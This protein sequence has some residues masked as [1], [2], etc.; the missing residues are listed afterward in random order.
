VKAMPDSYWHEWRG[1]AADPG[2]TAELPAGADVVVVGG[3][4][5]GTATAYWLARRGMKPVLLER[6]NL[7]AG[8][9]GRNGGL[10]VTG[11]PGAYPVAIARVGRETARAIWQFTV[12]N[13]T[14]LTEVLDSEKISCDYHDGGHLHLAASER[15][16]EHA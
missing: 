10:V 14:L 3:G 9:T 12:D 13:H 6:G 4:I 15:H 8:A 2:R 1:G 16:P 11:G 7:T 5:T